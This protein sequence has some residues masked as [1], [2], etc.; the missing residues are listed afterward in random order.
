MFPVSISIGSFNSIV[1]EEYGNG[2]GDLLSDWLNVGA[3]TGDA[4]YFYINIG[5]NSF[6]SGNDTSRGLVLYE[7]PLANQN[8]VNKLPTFNKLM[9]WLTNVENPSTNTWYD[10]QTAFRYFQQNDPNNQAQRRVNGISSAQAQLFQYATGGT[11]GRYSIAIKGATG[12]DMPS[13]YPTSGTTTQLAILGNFTNDLEVI[14][15]V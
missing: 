1:E 7:P 5:L 4:I 11:Y 13:G 2:V 9:Q 8:E 3:L 10:M 6:T 14:N 15:A 12:P